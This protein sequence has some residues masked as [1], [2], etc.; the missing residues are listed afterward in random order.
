MAF[1]MTDG[2]RGRPSILQ[3][4]SKTGAPTGAQKLSGMALS[5]M[6]PTT[7][8]AESWRLGTAAA[9]FHSAGRSGTP[10]RSRKATAGPPGWM[11]SAASSNAFDASGTHIRAHI[12]S[13]ASLDKEVLA[14]KLFHAKIQMSDLM[15][16]NVRPCLVEISTRGCFFALHPAWRLQFWLSAS[17]S[18][19]ACP[20]SEWVLPNNALLLPKVVQQGSNRFIRCSGGAIIILDLVRALWPCRKKHM[21]T[22]AVWREH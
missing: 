8:G 16:E 12:Q 4:P 1:H 19:Q 5:P 15:T 10:M 6:T 17:W 22:H 2:S 3:V 14:E 18:A 7:P 20:Q 9:D 13:L 21:Y 11:V